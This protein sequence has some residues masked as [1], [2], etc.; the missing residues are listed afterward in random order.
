[1]EI[2]QNELNY[3]KQEN[4]LMEGEMENKKEEI[5]RLKEK[6][7]ELKNE[8]AE[9]KWLQMKHEYDEKITMLEK[10]LKIKSKQLVDCLRRSL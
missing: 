4:D 3:F 2:L 5:D 6:Q 8:G 9:Q 7:K 1:M 10:A